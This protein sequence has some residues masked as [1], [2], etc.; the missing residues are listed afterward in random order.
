DFAK[1]AARV[2]QMVALGSARGVLAVH[3]IITWEYPVLGWRF[4]AL[5]L[6]SSMLLPVAA[7]L[8]A[9]LVVEVVPIALVSR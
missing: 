9:E 7:G 1:A 4:V 5:R 8:I 3:P 6:V 2:P